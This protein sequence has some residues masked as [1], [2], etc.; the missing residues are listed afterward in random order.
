MLHKKYWITGLLLLVFSIS[1]LYAQDKLVLTLDGSV[2]LAFKNN[3]SYQIALK[4][5]QKAKASIFTVRPPLP[6]RPLSRSFR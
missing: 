2:E 4:E 3:P 6:I 1:K 5:V